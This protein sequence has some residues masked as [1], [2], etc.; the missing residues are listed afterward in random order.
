VNESPVELVRSALDVLICR[1]GVSRDDADPAAARRVLDIFRADGCRGR[2]ADPSGCVLWRWLCVETGVAFVPL[3]DR[4]T[5]G[6][7]LLVT[8]A[9]HTQGPQATLAP[10]GH[11][12]VMGPHVT[13]VGRSRAAVALPTP[14]A[15]AVVVGDGWGANDLDTESESRAA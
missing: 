7:R 9:H 15:A 6:P 14:V 11:V 3:D 13:G 12:V 8:A 10:T 2:R 5:P 4:H 1:A